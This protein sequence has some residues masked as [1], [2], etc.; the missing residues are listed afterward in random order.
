MYPLQIALTIGEQAHTT[1]AV[2]SGG[3]GGGDHFGQKEE[4]SSQKWSLHKIYLRFPRKMDF[5]L[6]YR[7]CPSTE[8]PLAT[9]AGVPSRAK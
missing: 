6:M 7:S 2:K 5:E 3:E 9:K 4:E 8:V 1:V